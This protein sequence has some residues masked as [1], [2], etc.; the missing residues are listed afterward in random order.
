[1]RVEYN[2]PYTGQ[3]RTANIPYDQRNLPIMDDVA[4]FTTNINRDLSYDGQMRQATRDLRA[5]IQAGRVDP[6]QFTPQQLRDIQAGKST[7]DGYRWH[8]NAQGA[9]NSMQ[10]IPKTV[11][12]AVNHI[13]QGALSQGR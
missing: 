9:P 1:M 13:G 4:K 10:L 8:H 5:E 6:N 12:D 3:P 7:I 2:D 11:H